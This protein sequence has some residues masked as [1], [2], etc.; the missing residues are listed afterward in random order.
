MERRPNKTGPFWGRSCRWTN[1]LVVSEQTMRR[2]G[3][4]LARVRGPVK[5]GQAPQDR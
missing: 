2:G 1:D 4:H 3:Q 5:A